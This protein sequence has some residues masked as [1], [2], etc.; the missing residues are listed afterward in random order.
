MKAYGNQLAIF[1]GPNAMHP[2]G[3]GHAQK[4]D[5]NLDR[6]AEGS[7]RVLSRSFQTAGPIHVPVRRFPEGQ[8]RR[9]DPTMRH[10]SGSGLLAV[11]RPDLAI[12]PGL[13][14][15]DDQLSVL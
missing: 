3:Y 8:I 15:D 4:D 2:E 7:G 13:Q 9:P 11:Q 14:D 6:H 1:A 5:E 12:D 10:P